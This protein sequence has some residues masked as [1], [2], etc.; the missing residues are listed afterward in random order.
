MKRFK[1]LKL[2]GGKRWDFLFLYLSKKNQIFEFFF[3][4]K[5]MKTYFTLFFSK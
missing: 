1:L 4:D 5:K 2:N 3:D